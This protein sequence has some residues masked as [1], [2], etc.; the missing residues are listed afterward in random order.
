MS[1][2]PNPFSRCRR[3]A[4]RLAVIALIALIA[5]IA[6][7]AAPASR[8]IGGPTGA[9]SPADLPVM[10]PPDL[11]LRAMLLLV[12]ERRVY[13]PVTVLEALKAGP[14]LRAEL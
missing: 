14:E 1:I 2:R 9:G 7:W 8:A 12:A 13:E 10:Q 5:V 4:G 11:V 6:A 3:G